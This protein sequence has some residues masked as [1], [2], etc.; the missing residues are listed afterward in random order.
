MLL[1]KNGLSLKVYNIFKKKKKKKRRKKM[2]SN[3]QLY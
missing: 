2:D 3:L 1:L